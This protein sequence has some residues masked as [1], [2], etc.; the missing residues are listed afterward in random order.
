M[1]DFDNWLAEQDQI[2]AAIQERARRRAPIFLKAIGV[3]DFDVEVAVDAMRGAL[4]IGPEGPSPSEIQAELRDLRAA[5][6]AALEFYKAL[7]GRHWRR[8]LKHYSQE[9]V[10]E[11]TAADAY[12]AEQGWSQ[13]ELLPPSSVNG[14]AKFVAFQLRSQLDLLDSAMM[15]GEAELEKE[16]VAH[17]PRED[18]KRDLSLYYCFIAYGM[19]QQSGLRDPLPGK[20]NGVPANIATWWTAENAVE[21][22]TA[23]KVVGNAMALVRRVVQKRALSADDLD[24]VSAV[25]WQIPEGLHQLNALLDEILPDVTVSD[26]DFSNAKFTGALGRRGDDELRQRLGLIG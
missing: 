8:V 11:I 17:R 5:K 1:S 3:P 12:A 7:N 26:L 13:P 16:I 19:R 18:W 24:R 21:Y 4:D 9:V 15:A 20:R 25:K 14:P 6:K 23:E 2:A 10:S 22:S